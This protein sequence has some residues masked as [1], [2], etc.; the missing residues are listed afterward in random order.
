MASQVN[1]SGVVGDLQ[2]RLEDVKAMNAKLDAENE[3]PNPNPNVSPNPHPAGPSD[4][5][6]HRP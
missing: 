3:V 5:A 1:A 2:Q 4:A 6:P